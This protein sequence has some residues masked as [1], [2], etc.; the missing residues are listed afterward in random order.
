MC[1]TM[2]CQWQCTQWSAD[3]VDMVDMTLVPASLVS[4]V[5][6]SKM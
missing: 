2:Q 5:N 3:Q 4:I 1:P 6:S